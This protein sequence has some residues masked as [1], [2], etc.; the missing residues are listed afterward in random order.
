MTIRL[1]SGMKAYSKSLSLHVGSNELIYRAPRGKK[2]AV[3]LM[4]DEEPDNESG[5][6]ADDFLQSC[7]WKQSEHRIDEL[8]ALIESEIA[9]F[10]AGYDSPGEPESPE[11][12]Q[13]Q[14]LARLK[15]VF[16]AA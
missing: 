11:S 9:D 7:G 10:F 16:K 8:R 2:F 12:A 5:I 6:S 14:L 13:A 15:T 4:L 1:T 3:I